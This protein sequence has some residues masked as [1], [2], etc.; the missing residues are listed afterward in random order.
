[1]TR[2]RKPYCPPKPKPKPR[3]KDCCPADP[4]LLAVLARIATTLEQG[5]G[6]GGG[7]DY[8]PALE[9]I[10]DALE[11]NSETVRVMR[12]LT[13]SLEKVEASIALSTVSQNRIADVL[14]KDNMQRRGRVR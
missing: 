8:S 14:E 1:M 11:D 10:A 6:G 13:R 5:T 4:D 7:V 12:R 2:T 9:R 3:P